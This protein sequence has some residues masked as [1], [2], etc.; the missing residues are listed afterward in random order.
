MTFVVDVFV[1]LVIASYACTIA[2]VAFAKF[3]NSS[4]AASRNF[5]KAKLE[6]CDWLQEEREEQH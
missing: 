2:L 6:V 1:W 4:F 5:T 3:S